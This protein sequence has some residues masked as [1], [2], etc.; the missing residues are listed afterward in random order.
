M[1]NK[2]LISG[3]FSFLCFNSFANA[4]DLESLK[5]CQT[6][7]EQKIL[8]SQNY[9][10]VAINTQANATA[11]LVYLNSYEALNGSND[12]Y[13]QKQIQR[14]KSAIASSKTCS[15]I[16]EKLTANFKKDLNSQ[17]G[18]AQ[19]KQINTAL[20]KNLAENK[21]ILTNMGLLLASKTLSANEFLLNLTL[22]LADVGIAFGSK[23][24][25]TIETALSQLHPDLVD[26]QRQIERQRSKEFNLLAN[27]FGGSVPVSEPRYIEMKN[28]YNQAHDEV[29]AQIQSRN[30]K[31]TAQQIEL[32]LVQLHAKETVLAWKKALEK[33]N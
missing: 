16:R 11:A 7:D 13:V 26:Q 28:K 18:K 24:G 6:E 14:Y 5:T 19:L 23:G 4:M 2:L 21:E 32:I 29:I 30:E 1:Q 27:E 31:L 22:S 25:G 12:R 33:I 20:R 3:L 8:T 9:T 15:E 10:E 17:E